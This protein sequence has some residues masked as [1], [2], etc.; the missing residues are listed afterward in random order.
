MVLNISSY[1]QKFDSR[2]KIDDRP[3]S[4]A[5]DITTTDELIIYAS[6]ILTHK[7]IL[8][9]HVTSPFIDGTDYDNAIDLYKD[10]VLRSNEFDSVMSVNKIKTFLWSKDKP[11]NYSRSER[12]WPF[13]QEIKPFFEVNS[14]IFITSLE[15][16]KNLKDRIGNKPYLLEQD[17]KKSFDIDWEDDFFMAEQIGKTTLT[18]N[19]IYQQMP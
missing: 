9:T 17:S 14:G 12:K 11:V 2:V 15:I 10:K 6:R 1:F 4:Y 13:T 5:S 19:S 18:N 8:W 7:H 3:G 16:Y